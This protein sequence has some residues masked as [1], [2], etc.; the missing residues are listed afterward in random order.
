MKGNRRDGS[1]RNEPLRSAAIVS[2]GVYLACSSL[3][4]LLLGSY[5]DRARGTSYFAPAGLLLG[6]A[7]GLHR[8][9]TLVK[10]SA[11]RRK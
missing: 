4:G 6:L 5:I 8:A 9:Y 11:G 7:A 3:G 1:E 2:L 10:A